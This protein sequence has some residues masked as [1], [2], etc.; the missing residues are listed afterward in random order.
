M[1]QM[2]YSNY[3]VVT[4]KLNVSFLKRQFFFF[5]FVEELKKSELNKI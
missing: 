1:Q 3:I 4:K 5:L 2:C